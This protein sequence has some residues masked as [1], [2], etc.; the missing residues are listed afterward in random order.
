MTTWSDA[1][2]PAHDTT[3]TVRALRGESAS[4]PSAAARADAQS[5]SSGGSVTGAKASA[6]PPSLGGSL[7]GVKAVAGVPVELSWRAPPDAQVMLVRIERRADGDIQ[8]Q[9]SV[10][11]TGYRDR[12]VGRGK[13]Y[14]YR[15]SIAGSTDSPLL[16]ELE[17]GSGAT[18]R[19][20]AGA[21]PAPPGMPPAPPAMPA[22]A[23]TVD[24]VGAV[25]D[26]DG[27]L[28]VTWQW[29]PGV[30][31]AYV[32]FDARPPTEAGGQGRK[33]TNMRYEL[34]DGVLFDA[35]PA[36]AHV[37]VF[38]GRRDAAGV[39]RWGAAPDRSRTVAP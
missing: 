9:L 17:A 38:A 27:R 25:R 39:M 37:A 7:T 33:V 36:G 32:A 14:E 28:R 29:P 30:T 22:R 3:W 19:P 24:G 5:R 35:V 34:D 15:V 31:E 18:V 6:N 8:R 16:L 21:P 10:D 2:P 13:R 12:Q 20:S 11:A 26:A 4:A 1:Q 23:V